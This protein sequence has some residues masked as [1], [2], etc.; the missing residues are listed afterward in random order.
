MMIMMTNMTKMKMIM[1]MMSDLIDGKTGLLG[2]HMHLLPPQVVFHLKIN[3]VAFH[4]QKNG[5]I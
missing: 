5:S 2:Q 1:I 4:F 3:I